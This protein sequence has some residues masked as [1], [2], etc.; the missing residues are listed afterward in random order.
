MTYGVI[1]E[2]AAPV[3]M[4]DA[5]HAEVVRSTDAAADGLLLHV[6]RSTSD[7]F[8]VI[9]VWTD[10]DQFDRY[11]REVVWPAA[12]RLA[13][14]QSGAEPQMRTEEFEVRGLVLPAAHLVQ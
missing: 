7:G 11:N 8:Q 4:Y 10:K 6:G 12:A 14:G 9:E 13:D 3:E 2:V 1:V 5:L